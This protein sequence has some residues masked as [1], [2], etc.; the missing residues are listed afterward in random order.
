MPEVDV[1]DGLWFEPDPAEETAGEATS[2]PDA[3]VERPM[4]SEA[5]LALSSRWTERRPSFS[6]RRFPGRWVGV[7]AGSAL[8]GLVLLFV[9]THGGSA[10]RRGAP[11]T[12][13]AKALPS[14][15]SGGGSATP[16]VGQVVP[17]SPIADS[18][19]ATEKLAV[20]APPKTEKDLTAASAPP[21]EPVMVKEPPVKEPGVVKEPRPVN[22]RTV[23]EPVAEPPATPTA[24]RSSSGERR[25]RTSRTPTEAPPPATA[26]GSQGSSEKPRVRANPEVRMHN[27]VPLLD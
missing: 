5:W 20:T 11:G 22:E 25:A 15:Q 19:A 21:S 3:D 13:T 9:S 18:R 23:T 8:G 10:H 26:P 16:A 27:G 7:A 1:L 6:A 2:S 14:E 24:I 17:A 12:A 4:S